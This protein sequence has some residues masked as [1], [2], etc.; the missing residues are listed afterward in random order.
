MRTGCMLLLLLLIASG[1]EAK[2]AEKI[3]L[4]VTSSINK[5]CSYT[6]NDLKMLPGK[7]IVTRNTWRKIPSSFQGPYIKSIVDSCNAGN[8]TTTIKVKA[9]NDYMISI[10]IED[11]KYQPI[12]AIIENGNP[13]PRSTKGPIWVMYP[14]SQYPELQNLEIDGKLIWQVKEMVLQ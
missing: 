11:L 2:N 14:V 3:V 6:M 12:L 1:A 9:L 5:V 10:P 13:I 4:R 7:E 8:K